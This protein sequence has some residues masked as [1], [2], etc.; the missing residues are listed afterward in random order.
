MVLGSPLKCF[1]SVFQGVPFPILSVNIII[2]S[3]LHT[4]EQALSWSCLPSYLYF[5][6][7]PF[8]WSFLTLSPR[9]PKGQPQH[10]HLCP[11][12]PVSSSSL[13]YYWNLH[14]TKYI[15][16]TSFFFIYFVSFLSFF[17][18]ILFISRSVSPLASICILRC[19]K[20]FPWSRLG[21]CIY[22][23]KLLEPLVSQLPSIP[24]AHLYFSVFHDLSP[25]L[26]LPFH[27]IFCFT[28]HHNIAGASRSFL[29]YICC[30][31]IYYQTEEEWTPRKTLPFWHPHTP[32]PCRGLFMHSLYHFNIFFTG[33]FFLLWSPY[34]LLGNRIAC[35]FQLNERPKHTSPSLS[36][37]L[38]KLFPA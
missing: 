23:H 10:P 25:S 32:H 8:T 35:F 7:F 33:I 5:L 29:S 27:L 13:H 17:S 26:Q 1:F 12:M 2:L 24:S 20:W 30:N 6:L 15:W 11:P 28:T 22:I 14:M 9:E 16:H 18:L 38:Y 19:S 31:N 37:S 36:A 21:T 3:P 34:L 4:S